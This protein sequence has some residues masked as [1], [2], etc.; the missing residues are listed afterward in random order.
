MGAL[1]LFSS[2]L[3]QFGSS[4]H[5]CY[6]SQDGSWMLPRAGFC[7]QSV[8]FLMPQGADPNCRD[9]EEQPVITKAVVNKHHEVIPVLVQRGADTEQRW[10]P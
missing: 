5:V 8:L 10:G 2:D 9:G 1:I 3:K 7:G 6:T 4:K